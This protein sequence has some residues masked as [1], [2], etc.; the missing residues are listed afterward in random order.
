MVA[1]RKWKK[2]EKK[3]K[4]KSKKIQRIESNKDRKGKKRENVSVDEEC[5][6]GQGI[7]ERLR[8]GR[9]KQYIY[10]KQTKQ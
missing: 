6:A 1:K 8:E 10:I 3:Q 5:L 9:K 7:G 4:K 2:S